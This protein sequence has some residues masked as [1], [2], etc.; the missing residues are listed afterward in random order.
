[1]TPAQHKQYLI[2]SIGEME[3][4]VDKII[5]KIYEQRDT[6]SD[7]SLKTFYGIIDRKKEAISEFKQ[8]LATEYDYIIQ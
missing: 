4:F 1:M 2:D 7:N 6:I 3:A 8:I 5:G